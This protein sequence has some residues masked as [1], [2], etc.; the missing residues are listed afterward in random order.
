MN[1]EIVA[2][3]PRS[4]LGPSFN[5]HTDRQMKSWLCMGQPRCPPPPQRTGTTNMPKRKGWPCG[6]DCPACARGSTAPL[7]RQAALSCQLGLAR[8][9]LPEQ[10][11]NRPNSFRSSPKHSTFRR[12]SN[13]APNR[14]QTAFQTAV[15]RRGQG[16]HNARNWAG[17]VGAALNRCGPSSPPAL[18]R[19]PLG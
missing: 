19:T 14:G 16:R 10:E 12:R 2:R 5:T 7:N 4:T 15:K 9:H 13:G 8:E 1:D 17:A 6:A 3:Q 18:P 11:K